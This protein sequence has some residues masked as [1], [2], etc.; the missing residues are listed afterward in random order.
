MAGIARRTAG[1]RVGAG[2]VALVAA[3]GFAAPA[4]G[5]DH[6]NQAAQATLVAPGAPARGAISPAGDVDWFRVRVAAGA[7]VVVRTADLGPGMDTVLDVWG[8]GGQAVGTNDDVDGGRQSRVTFVAARTGDAVARVRHYDRTRGVGTYALVVDVTGAPAPA[9]TTASTTT[10][11]TTTTTGPA[12]A[13]GAAIDL[14]AVPAFDPKLEGAALDVT[15]RVPGGGQ[16]QATLDVLD[17]QGRAVARLVGG[18]VPAGQALQASWD[19]RDAGGRFVAPGRYALRA[20]ATLPGGGA[21]AG[22]RA[23]HVV[24]VG[25]VSATF[26]DTGPGGARVQLAYHAPNGRLDGNRLALDAMGAAWTLSR[27]PLGDGCL[28][29]PDGAPLALPAV[30]TDLAQPPRDGAGQVVLRGRSLPVAYVAGARPEVRLGLGDRAAAGGAAVPCGYPVAGHPLRVAFAGEVTRELAPGG[31]VA[32]RLPAVAGAIGRSDLELPLTFEVLEGG[33]WRRVP[34]LHRLAV[35]VY[36]VLGAPRQ[37]G[38]LERPWVAAVDRVAGW[39]AGRAGTAAEALAAIV[40]ALNAREGLRYDGAQGAPAYTDG[41]SLS[42]PDVLLDQWLHRLRGST[43]NCLDCA[44]LVTTLADAVGVAAEV[45][46]AGWNFALHWI[47]GL[48][49]PGFTRDLFG[50]HHAFSYHAV[51][52]V[53]RGASVHDACLRVDDDAWPQASPHTARLPIAMPFARYRAQLS[54]DGFRV[55]ELGR[56]RVR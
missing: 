4:R 24:R 25:L 37:G 7:R 51:A 53:D 42:R 48:G 34:G 39:S 16:A 26:A 21:A 29:A 9:D 1:P 23:V 12:P 43:V 28:D 20:A 56:A 45:A 10:T 27:S 50:G 41:V 13:P 19:G 3:A 47:Q 5:D 32:L 44:G 38:G 35:R 15:W 33:A 11:G 55:E 14:D 46:I 36:T 6:G 52:S 18:L 17:A 2:L 31:E 40:E 49:S 22:E 8:P 54:P 30:W